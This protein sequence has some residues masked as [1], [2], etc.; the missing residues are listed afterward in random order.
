MTQKAEALACTCAHLADQ[1]KAEDVIVLHVEPI[2]FFTDYFVIATGR[3]PRQIRA[4][5]E[6]VRTRARQLDR[7]VLGVEGE[8][9]AG[10]VL[11]DIG[12]VIV[13]LFDPEARDLYDLELLWGEADRTAWQE[14]DP[15]GGPARTESRS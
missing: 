4:I 6:E 3:N 7:T 14:S 12:G 2:A 15:L 13:H 8:P 1:H 9:E 11:I 10:W 5:A